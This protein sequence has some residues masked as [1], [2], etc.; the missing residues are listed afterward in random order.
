MTE[1]AN[2]Q[3]VAPISACQ[4]KSQ[5]S[6]HTKLIIILVSSGLAVLVLIA[7]IVGYV[8]YQHPQKVVTDSLINLMNTRAVTADGTVKL[9]SDVADVTA[10]IT[11]GTSRAGSTKSGADIEVIL[12]QA[13]EN[14][15]HK[16]TLA[17]DVVTEKNGTVYFRL[18]H[19]RD[20]VKA[21]L[22]HM[23][24]TNIDDSIALEETVNTLYDRFD[25]L[26]VQLDNKWIKISPTGGD[27][28]DSAQAYSCIQEATASLRDDP[29]ARREVAESYKNNQFITVDKKSATLSSYTYKLGI[30]KRTAQ[31]FIKAIENTSFGKKLKSCNSDIFRTMQGPTSQHTST[32]SGEVTID[33]SRWTHQLERVHA[34]LVPDTKNQSTQVVVDTALKMNSPETFEVPKQATDIKNLDLAS[35]SFLPSQN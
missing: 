33:V 26:L 27:S 16:I 8:W 4:N 13:N 20:S 6:S 35:L 24:A 31:S 11:S 22:K 1:N 3:A 5:K 18:E 30:E 28:H 10:T 23:L 12:K 17:A 32:S 7:L 14:A 29:S 9:K 25:P 21:A 2:G 19:L 34:S 15:E